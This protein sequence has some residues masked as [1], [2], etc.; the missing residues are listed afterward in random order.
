V[1]VPG[2]TYLTRLLIKD[3]PCKKQMRRRQQKKFREK[4]PIN[5]STQTIL[6]NAQDVRISG[7]QFHNNSY[8]NNQIDLTVSVTGTYPFLYFKVIYK[9]M[10]FRTRTSSPT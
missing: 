5:S 4:Q 1:L 8:S 3:S 9:V 10:S 2:V 7:V 6:E